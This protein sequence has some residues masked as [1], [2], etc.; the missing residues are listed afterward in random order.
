M[1]GRRRVLRHLAGL[2]ALGAGTGL[3]GWLGTG[4]LGSV[5]AA[6]YRALVCIHLNGGCDG[7]DVLVPTDAAFADYTRA[8]GEIALP[9]S[10]LTALTGS[11][12]GHTFGVNA[13][14]APLA[15]MYASGRLAFMANVGPL[16]RPVTAAQVLAGTAEV[17][18]FLLSH[19][20]QVAIQH[21]W[22]GDED[23]SGWAGRTL[24]SLSADFR[25]SL[26]AVTVGGQQTL[27]TGRRSRVTRTNAGG[28]CCWGPV[29]LS[30]PEQLG[31][32]LVARLAE[33]QSPNAYEAEYA[34]TML[35]GFDDAI[36]LQNALRQAGT[37][38]GSFASDGIGTPLRYL[39]QLLPVFK[40]Q[41]K[42]RQVFVV[43]WGSFDTHSNQ[44]GTGEIA[45]DGQLAQLAAALAA[46]DQ[47]LRVAG[48]D[49][50]VVT[51]TMSDFGRTLKP[52]SGAG[53]DHAWGNH[54]LVFGGPVQ[55][56][57]VYGQFPSLV[58][59][60]ADDCD[61]EGEGRWVPT[62]ATDQLGA[63]LAT[64]LGMPPGALYDVFPNLVNFGQPRLPLFG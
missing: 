53:T 1:N 56:G 8:R 5:Q 33:L 54:H 31:T 40:A 64:W 51:F 47:S 17:P 55:G 63:A 35:R 13:A 18:P 37:P 19:S 30:R 25:N 9:R 28:Q 22:G 50:N 43:D 39:A 24:E 4:G 21:G 12:A 44:R 6:D 46:F 57:Q 45:Q 3:A 36:E 38:A 11:S 26:S 10:S 2:S 42:R 48:L 62:T 58:L 14:L 41:G 29:D 49:T 60:G 34:R 23:Q 27:I 15:P 32:R 7:N 20:D 52:A 16:I 59:G 61:A